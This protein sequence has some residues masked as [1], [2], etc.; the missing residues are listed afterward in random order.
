[1]HTFAGLN[2]LL[3]LFGFGWLLIRTTNRQ[4]EYPREV[5]L[6]LLLVLGFFFTLLVVSIEMWTRDINTYGAPAITAVKVF[7]I[8]V[9]LKNRQTLFRTGTRTPDGVGPDDCYHP[10]EDI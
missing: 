2:I 5:I 9:L 10:N 3:G 4:H 6:L 1:M 8:Y 7:A